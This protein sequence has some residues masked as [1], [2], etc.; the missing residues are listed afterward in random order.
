[1][2]LRK[3][4]IKTFI[5]NYGKKMWE[6]S[7]VKFCGFQHMMSKTSLQLLF[8]IPKFISSV[9]IAECWPKKTTGC[10]KFYKFRTYFFV[11]QILTELR[12]ATNPVHN[13]EKINK[14]LTTFTSRKLPKLTPQN[15]LFLRP[16]SLLLIF[17]ILTYFYYISKQELCN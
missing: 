9:F 13:E 4:T 5:F 16:L 3:N 10:Q 11:L 6:K 8:Q 7:F 2:R 17:I 15:S 1:M 12:F 14:T